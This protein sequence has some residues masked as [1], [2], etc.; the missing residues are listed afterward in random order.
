M[1][2]KFD[3][4]VQQTYLRGQFAEQKLMLKFSYRCDLI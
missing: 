3:L 2:L 1:L 4:D